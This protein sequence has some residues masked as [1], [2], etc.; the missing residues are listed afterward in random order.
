MKVEGADGEEIEV[1]TAD[2]VQ[3]RETAA[4]AAK[5]AEYAPKITD[6]EG[7]LTDTT[8]RLNERTGEFAQFRKLNDEQ[9]AKLSEAE[10]INYENTLALQKSEEARVAAETNAQK[11]L[12]TT[13]IKV[14]AGTNTKLEEE[15]TKAWELVNVVATTPE[16]VELKAQMVL[17]MLSVQQP[18]LVASANGFNGGFAPPAPP[19]K[20]GDSFAD[21]DAGK[22]LANELGLTLEPKK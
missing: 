10:R 2:E 22:T 8:K 15:M 21:T 1:Y 7:K 18:D 4:A 13:A 9:V 3:A 19:R 6:L 20:E 14:K 16:E 5:E 12:V 11:S 17:G